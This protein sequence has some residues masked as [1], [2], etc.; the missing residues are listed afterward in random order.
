MKKV[1]VLFVALLFVAA[2]G[3]TQ[4]ATADI[5]GKVLSEDGGPLPGVTVTLTGDKIG[6]RT[7]VTTEEG[8][9]RFLKLPVGNYTVKFELEGFDTVVKKGLVLHVG[10][11]PEVRVTMKV[12]KLT[13][14]IVVKAESTLINTRKA[15]IGTN[16]TKE[17][18]A[19]LPTSRNPWTVMSLV[20]GM[21][22][23]REDVGGNESGQQSKFIG[24]GVNDSDATWSVDGANI[25][26]PSAVGAAPAYLNVNAYE[27]M[28][29]T[30][31]AN[32]IDAMTGGVQLNFVTKR[33]GNNYSGDFHLYVEDEAWE[34]KRTSYPEKMPAKYKD[35]G[36]YRL[37]QY[38]INFGGP[39]VKDKAWWFGSWTVQD[40]HS[41]TIVQTEDA[42]WL[43]GG[44]GKINFQFGNTYG[45][46]DVHYD[47]KK[48]WG[49]SSLGAANQ[50]PGTLFDQTG[51]SN[52]FKGDLQQVMGNLMLEAKIAYTDGGFDL[53]PR[54]SHD[55]NGYNVGLDWLYYR[56]PSL[57]YG[58]SMYH[59]FTNRNTIDVSLTGNYFLEGVLGGDHEIKFGGTY[60]TAT[61]TSQTLLPNQRRLFIYSKTSPNR[62]REIWWTENG[63]FD[64]GFKRYSAFVSDTFTAG[65]ITVNLGL[66]YDEQ[67]S[68]LNSIKAPGI[69]W[70]GKQ[71]FTKWIPPLTTK[72]KDSPAKYAVISPRL[73]I[74]YDLT[75]D[76][77][78]VVK[79]SIARY[80]S[81]PGNNLAGWIWYG[82]GREIDVAWKDKNGNGVPDVGEWSEDKSNW[83]W[84]NINTV[85]PT[86]TESQNKFDPNFNS[87]LL[88]E[89]VL[90]FQK[91]LSDDLAVSLTGYY[92]KNHNGVRS[93][94][95]MDANGTL[96]T[97]DNW[98]EG[99]EYKF[100]DGHKQKYWLR[101]KKP[102]YG[103]YYTN[104]KK[105]YTRY[106]A[107]QVVLNKRLSHKW[108]ANASFT[109]QDWKSYT[110]KSEVFDFTNY[111]Y[112]YGG[113]VA[114][115]SGGSGLSGIY[116]NARWTAKFMGLYQLPYNWNI[117]AVFQAREGYIL[118]YH[119]SHKR[120]GGIGWTSM[121]EYKDGVKFGD[122]RLPTFW[123]LNLSL[124]KQFKVS[125]RVT[126]IFHVDGYN[127][128][129]N[130][131]V[132]KK[133]TTLGTSTTNQVQ[134]ILNPT[135]F[136]FGIQVKF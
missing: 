127:I 41:R 6:T 120:G 66:R 37:Y 45:D 100:K 38:G 118:P 65:K 117:S 9:F 92:K 13:E 123:L 2:F 93:I 110:D 57:Y 111:D 42:T 60:Y 113:V 88:D 26:D 39:L 75:G 85:D 132:L 58:G 56:T 24:L 133:N 20:P 126:A 108:M 78:N 83:I 68:S 115:K 61:T 47:N 86:N 59:Y 1:L 104:Y 62:Y 97:K 73:S 15:T 55:E 116:V 87:P 22:I 67:R 4:T 48:K 19:E 7:A 52:V 23:D 128:T 112:F 51:P 33:A 17:M 71:I 69:T 80:G 5:H 64:V 129:N 70:N 32:N 12:S 136:Q 36:I 125:D 8:N 95:M 18:I 27:E 74:N 81:Q 72:A 131:T 82:G 14:E 29:L 135:V 96:E 101:H 43:L 11:D 44:Y 49:R 40:I 84:W 53:Q 102:A 94:G 31:G 25:T 99:G 54:G 10:D 119:E 130:S 109:Y 90:S 121:Y 76:G 105:S 124:Q 28:Q 46:F 63:H 3:Y 114:P 50:D 30:L 91:A 89:L 21:M 34:L 103:K 107:A 134:R 106:M 98:Y 79:L 122:D 35:P 77:K 16:I